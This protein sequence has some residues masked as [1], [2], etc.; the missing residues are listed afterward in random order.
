MY[1]PINIDFSKKI[2]IVTIFTLV[3]VI[4]LMI[5]LPPIFRTIDKEMHFLFYFFSAAFLN[6]LFG[7]GKFLRHVLIF[8]FL[9]CFGYFIEHAQEYSNRFFSK[10]IH[11]NYD[12]ADIKYNIMGLVLFSSLWIFSVVSHRIFTTRLIN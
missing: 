3:S 5:K 7:N 2:V 8:A 4:G 11:G 12:F 10:R 1:Q 9:L 6:L